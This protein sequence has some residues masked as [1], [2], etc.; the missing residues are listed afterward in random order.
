MV[1]EV[2]AMGVHVVRTVEPSL[3]GD[4]PDLFPP[5]V[6]ARVGRHR[7]R[8]SLTAEDQR[9]PLLRAACMMENVDAMRS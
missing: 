3:G 9:Y 4:G 8:Y 6:V 2:V 7:Q 1:H 5:Q